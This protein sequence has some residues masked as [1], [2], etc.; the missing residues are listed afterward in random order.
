MLSSIWVQIRTPK[1]KKAAASPAA[2]ERNDRID[3]LLQ[4]LIKKSRASAN[5]L[6][7]YYR[8]ETGHRISNQSVSPVFAFELG[9]SQDDLGVSF[10]IKCTLSTPVLINI[11]FISQS[12]KSCLNRFFAYARA[13]IRNLFLCKLA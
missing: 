3:T 13:D 10:R 2:N 12:F 11:A 6:L 9:K 8:S 7:N 1:N 5:S 4:S